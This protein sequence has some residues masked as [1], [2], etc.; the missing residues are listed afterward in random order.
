[1]LKYLSLSAAAAL[2]FAGAAHAIPEN[3]PTDDGFNLEIPEDDG[4][5]SDDGWNLGIDDDLTEDG[6]IIPDGVV[7]DRLGDIAEI[8]T[9]EETTPEISADI[10]TISAPED[11]LIRLD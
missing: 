8:S 1:M 9:G 7:Q 5:M 6:F 3:P 4:G 10:P 11:D 2:A